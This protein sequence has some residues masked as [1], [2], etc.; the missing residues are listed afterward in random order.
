MHRLDSLKQ[1]RTTPTKT[2]ENHDPLQIPQADCTQIPPANQ[3]V[4]AAFI[5]QLP[6]QMATAFKSSHFPAVFANPVEPITQHVAM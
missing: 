6:D 4:W 5:V 1:G 3:S 2:G